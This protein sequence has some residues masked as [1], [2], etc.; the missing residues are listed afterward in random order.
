MFNVLKSLPCFILL[1]VYCF[2]AGNLYAQEG[3]MGIPVGQLPSGVK[4]ESL[5]PAQ[6][7]AVESELSRTGGQL[8]PEAIE[9]LK[10]SPEFQGVKPGDSG[11]AKKQ[12]PASETSEEIAITQVE[13][14][15]TEVLRRFGMPFFK[16]ARNRILTLEEMMRQGKRPPVDQ[17]DALSG[18]V[19]PLDMVSS[20]VNATIPPQYVLNPGD[21]VIIH[22]WGDLLELTELSLT[23]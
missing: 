18:F 15:N 8:T 7:Q 20:Y 19:G 6:R 16:P 14:K 22:Y 10:K 9:T 12:E 23:L 11:G 3:R 21:T 5:T 17:R 4:L 13:E 2:H 1:S